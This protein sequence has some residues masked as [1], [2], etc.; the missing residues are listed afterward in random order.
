MA[1]AHPLE[2][3]E[4]LDLNLTDRD[5]EWLAADPERKIVVYVWHAV[6]ECWIFTK[7]REEVL[8]VEDVYAYTFMPDPDEAMAQ[9]ESVVPEVCEGWTRLVSFYLEDVAL[10]N[11][12]A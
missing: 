10:V 3:Y 4:W 9:M 11:P 2:L 8:W 1:S 5:K 7:G 12:Y 6:I